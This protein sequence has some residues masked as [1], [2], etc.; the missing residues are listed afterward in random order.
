[1]GPRP[2]LVIE[3]LRQPP[4]AG[5]AESVHAPH[6]E[7]LDDSCPPDP[8]MRD[9]LLRPGAAGREGVAAFSDWLVANW[10]DVP[11]FLSEARAVLLLDPTVADVPP[12]V[13]IFGG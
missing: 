9:E 3:P 7:T 5:P 10:T 6:Y 11:Y 2:P 13:R 8:Q 4:Q 12:P 1:M